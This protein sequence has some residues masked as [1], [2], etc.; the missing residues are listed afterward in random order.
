MAKQTTDSASLSGNEEL[1]LCAQRAREAELL[2]QEAES[3]VQRL[4]K[5]LKQVRK[6]YKKAKNA[7][8]DAA[9]AA[10]KAQAELSGCLGGAFRQLATALEHEAAMQARDAA[11]KIEPTKR[12]V[13]EGRM[14]SAP[15][16][17][18]RSPQ[19]VSG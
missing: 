19:T 3:E 15:G 12:G 11:E 9:K 17:E 14:L 2:T 10:G 7:A 4:R 16:A 8:K 1:Q 6:A 13:S 5:E 18:T